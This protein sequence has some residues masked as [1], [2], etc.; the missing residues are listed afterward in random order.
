MIV[1]DL[2]AFSRL[3][4]RQKQSSVS[5]AES[6]RLKGRRKQNLTSWSENENLQAVNQLKSSSFSTKP[7]LS[8]ILN[9]IE[10]LSDVDWYKP[11]ANCRAEGN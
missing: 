8:E 11:L 10:Q 9:W 2:I 4:S 6:R 1:L 3:Q 5:A 7:P